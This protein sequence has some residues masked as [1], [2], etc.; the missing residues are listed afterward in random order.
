MEWEF[1]WR[2][3]RWIFPA[4]GWLFSGGQRKP[5]AEPRIAALVQGGAA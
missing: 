3:P 1:R 4:E 2:A 5:T